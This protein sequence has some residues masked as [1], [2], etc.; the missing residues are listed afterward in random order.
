MYRAATLSLINSLRCNVQSTTRSS[1]FNSNTAE[2]WNLY[3]SILVER[4]PII[5]KELNSLE[6][7]FQEYL[8]HVEF[9]K[10]LKSNHEL[11]HERDLK[12][13]QLLKQGQADLDEIIA[14]QTAQDLKDAYIEELKQFKLSSRKTSDDKTNNEMSIN[15][16]LEDTL[17]LLVQQK[18]GKK[19]HFLLPQGPRLDGETMR[20]AAERVLEE[21]CGNQLKVRFYGNAPCGFYKYKYPINMRDQAV[22][23]KV[24]F[25]RASLIGGDVDKNVTGK[26]GWVRKEALEDKLNNSSYSQS[27]QKIIL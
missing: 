10:S 2:K 17:Y 18:L 21:K 23:A 11:Q 13:A 25:Y 4:L 12:Q 9:E 22:G 24:F 6:K 15:R 26:Y 3:A 14:K 1:S 16:C 8:R 19:E 20:Q 7:E 27:V 5:S